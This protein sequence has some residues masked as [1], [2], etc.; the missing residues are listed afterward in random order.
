M[1]AER[2]LTDDQRRE[3][4]E[5]KKMEEEKKGIIG[6]VFKCVYLPSPHPFPPIFLS[7]LHS[8]NCY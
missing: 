7:S 5:N 8:L 6:A 3:K 2:K 1:N 4:V